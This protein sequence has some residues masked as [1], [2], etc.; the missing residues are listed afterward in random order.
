MDPSR[1]ICRG[2]QRALSPWSK[3]EREQ[4]GTIRQH[5]PNHEQC[6]RQNDSLC[7]S[8][9]PS[10]VDFMNHARN[11]WTERDTFCRDNIQG[12]PKE[13]HPFRILVSSLVRWIIFAIFVYSLSFWLNDIVLCVQNDVNKFC[14]ARINYNFVRMVGLTNDHR[15]LI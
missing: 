13:W 5:C 1:E 2:H 4:T 9:K 6:L 3:R 8:H 14:F 11:R 7:A 12:G 10:L 15:R